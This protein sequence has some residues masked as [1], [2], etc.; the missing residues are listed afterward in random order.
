MMFFLA[1][2]NEHDKLK[3]ERLYYDHRKLMYKEAYLILRDKHLAEDALSEAFVKIIKNLHKIDENDIPR[4]RS[5]LVIVCRNVAKSIYM[6]KKGL[7]EV[8]ALETVTENDAE[9]SNNPLDIVIDKE[10]FDKVTSAIEALDH[11]FRDVFLLRRVY[12]LSR[13][14]I[15]D[16]CDISVENVK[17]RLVRS[18]IK[19]LKVLD[20]EASKC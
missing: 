16:I 15:A 5:F 6:K 2:E 7:S 18:K 3:V 12:G 20:K 19:I 14:D 9:K 13:E 4:T 11:D 8:S 10:T 1:I 17:K